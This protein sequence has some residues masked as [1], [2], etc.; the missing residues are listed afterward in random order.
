MANEEKASQ[1]VKVLY[2]ESHDEWQSRRFGE[3]RFQVVAENK[4]TGWKKYA[5]G[6]DSTPLPRKPMSNGAML[7]W[8]AAN[9]GI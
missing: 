6:H 8:I 1:Q 5:D 7:R 2:T 9:I 4:E 3:A